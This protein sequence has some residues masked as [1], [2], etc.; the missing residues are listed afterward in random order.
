[1]KRDNIIDN[2][3]KELSALK[4]SLDAFN[5]LLDNIDSI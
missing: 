3:I 5:A 4:T 1:M 2:K